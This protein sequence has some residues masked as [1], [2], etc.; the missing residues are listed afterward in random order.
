MAIINNYVKYARS[1]ATSIISISFCREYPFDYNGTPFIITFQLHNVCGV[2]F[3]WC[4]E[5]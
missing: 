5:A 3:Q 1:D 2:L 4:D